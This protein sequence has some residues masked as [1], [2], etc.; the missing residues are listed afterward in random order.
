MFDKKRGK[1]ELK[2]SKNIE[3]SA[4]SDSLGGGGYFYNLLNKDVK[5]INKVF[6]SLFGIGIILIAGFTSYK[7]TN[8]SYALFS[9]TITGEKTI[10]VEVTNHLDRSGANP[11][12][13]D[14]NM[15]PVYYDVEEEL[16]KKADKENKIKEYKWY[17]YNNKMWANSVTYD[18]ERAYNEG[19]TYE[20]RTFSGSQYINTG[21]ASYNFGKTI[22]IAARFKVSKTGVS[23]HII[24]NA[25]AAGAY[26]AISSA[27]KI[28]FYIYGT[29]AAAYKSVIS[30]TTVT[31]GKWYT[32]VATYNGSQMRLY[33]NGVY[34]SSISITDTIKTS[35]QPIFIGANPNADGVHQSYFYGTVEETL[36][37]KETLSASEVEKH[38]V[39]NINYTPSSNLVFHKKYGNQK[40][41]LE[42]ADELIASAD[43][44][45]LLDALDE[46]SVATLDETDEITDIG[47]KA[48]RL[49][50]KIVYGE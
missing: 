26:M 17:D 27:N 10:E 11:P 25:E 3:I 5:E 8:T 32:A 2:A 9:D 47:R 20:G 29:K 4:Y 42:N 35:T 6:I 18:H 16:W 46:L 36:V 31:T 38:Y 49:I 23:Q 24:S 40:T 22:T 30:T 12:E 37:L 34:E 43:T 14:S 13:L 41:Y 19:N 1:N 39:D 15:I 48:E 28:T 21:N 33:V 44:Y 7:L 45:N 50:D